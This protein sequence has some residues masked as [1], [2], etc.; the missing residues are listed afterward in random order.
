MTSNARAAA[1]RVEAQSVGWAALP[2]WLCSLFFAV[3]CGQNGPSG[4]VSIEEEQ[5]IKRTLNGR[6]FRQ[7]EPSVDASPRKGVIL[8]F[9]DGFSLWAQ[10]ARD[11]HAIDEWEVAA[12]DYRIEKASDNS[13]FKVFFIGPFSARAFPEK[14][15]NCV[16]TTGVS[17]LIRDLFDKGR[18][19]FK[20]NDPDGILPRPFPVFDSWT[21]FS[22]DEYFD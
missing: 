1:E 12:T 7:F 17:V 2:V 13:E 10:Y 16:Q 15:E 14:C 3:S 4:P 8:D 21:K 19:T 20:I 18:T 22:E 9:T 5:R 6:S 11:G